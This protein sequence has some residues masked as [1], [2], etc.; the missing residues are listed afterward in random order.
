MMMNLY[1]LHVHV[2]VQGGPLLCASF[3]GV[4]IL[5]F[6]ILKR[7]LAFPSTNVHVTENVKV[8]FFI[9]FLKKFS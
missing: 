4:G 6:A 5:N 7:F 2:A 1:S 9:F 3:V 8:D